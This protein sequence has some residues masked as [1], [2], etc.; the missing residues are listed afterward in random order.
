[1]TAFFSGAIIG[2]VGIAT[3]VLELPSLLQHLPDREILAAV[4]V[5]LAPVPDGERH[6]RTSGQIGQF[7]DHVPLAVL[8]CTLRRETL[9]SAPRGAASLGLHHHRAARGVPVV[10][11]HRM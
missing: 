7:E 4:A 5:L 6:G 11:L 3:P 2:I 9:T 10:D 1:E 8:I